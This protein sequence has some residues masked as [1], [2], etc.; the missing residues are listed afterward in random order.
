MICLQC[1]HESA[2]GTGRC[3]SCG[4][5]LNQSHPMNTTAPAGAAVSDSTHA[6][7][8]AYSFDPARWTTADRVTGAATIVLF[9]SLFLPW[10]SASASLGGISA[11][12]S[13]DGLTA[14]G[15][16]YFVLILCLVMVGYL[17]VRA[18][19]NNM[20]ALPLSHERLLTVGAGINLLLVLIAVIF[21]PSGGGLVS[22]G[23]DFGSFVALIAAIVAIAPL[24]RMELEARRQ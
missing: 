11:S 8:Q 4:T 20:P 18:G 16:L 13:A 17:V 14:H 6:R 12:S 10:F 21:K 15:Y 9:I 1:G 19:L 7:P 5:A 2:D 22:V 3:P 24:A 23:W